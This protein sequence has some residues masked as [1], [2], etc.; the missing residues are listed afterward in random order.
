MQAIRGYM[1]YLK[2]ILSFLIPLILSLILGP[3][4]IRFAKKIGIIDKPNSRGIHTSPTPLAGGLSFGIPAILFLVFMS[5][6]FPEYQMTLLFQALGSS[7]I[8]ILGFVDD[9]L[10]FTA[11][12]K[13]IFQII[14]VV[15]MY[16]AG[17]KIHDLTNPFGHN[18]FLGVFSFPFTLIWFLLVINAFNLIDG[19]DGLASGI[20]VIV[21]CVL[22]VV[23]L[24][25]GNVLVSLISICLMGSTLGFLRINFYPAKIFMG[26]TGSLFLG[27]NIAA[28]AIIGSG[29]LKGIA[30][31]T[32]LI[33]IIALIIPLSDTTMAIYRR[34]KRKKHIFHADKEHLHHKLL[35]MGL[36]QKAIALISYFVTVLFGLIA[37]GF[38]ITSRK[39]LLAILTMLMILIFTVVYYILKKEFWK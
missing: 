39:I 24:I 2:Y 36:S 6:H 20:A 30:T 38:S 8:L 29:Q 21:F 17:F 16:H 34:I 4:N 11:R 19:L 33:P 31:M 26:D 18:I 25:Y 32:L 10:K 35:D 14:I 23:G 1:S 28:L 9:K 27:L 13:L 3:I 12:Y 5:F 22:F 7:L 37:I 15:I